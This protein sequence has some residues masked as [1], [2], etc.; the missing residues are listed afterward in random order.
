[1]SLVKTPIGLLFGAFT[2]TVALL[3]AALI[4]IQLMPSG[5]SGYLQRRF[6]SRVARN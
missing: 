1:L 4:I 2:G 5:V 6:E 3:F